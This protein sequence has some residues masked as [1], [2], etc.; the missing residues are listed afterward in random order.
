MPSFT[1]DLANV[2]LTL[3]TVKLG[4]ISPFHFLSYVLNNFRP[5]LGFAINV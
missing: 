3:K 5:S 4:Y 1:C 2:N